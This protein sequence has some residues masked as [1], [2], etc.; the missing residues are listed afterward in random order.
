V[1]PL[2]LPSLFKNIEKSKVTSMEADIN[3]IKTATLNYYSDESQLPEAADTEELTGVLAP[4]IESISNPFDATYSF[5]IEE[6]KF[7]LVITDL[8]LNTASQDKIEADI[9]NA[10]ATDAQVKVPLIT[11]DSI[12]VPES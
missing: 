1:P 11:D 5:E 8:K 6:G 4:Y 12:V 2:L 10:E 9:P 3:T 7:N